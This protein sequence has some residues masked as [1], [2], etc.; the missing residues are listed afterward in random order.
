MCT[1]IWRDPLHWHR[2]EASSS[3][4]SDHWVSAWC[5]RQ[6]KSIELSKGNTCSCCLRLPVVHS[7]YAEFVD[8]VVFAIKNSQG[9]GYAWL[10]VFP[11]YMFWTI[12]RLGGNSGHFHVFQL[13][14]YS[15]TVWCHMSMSRIKWL[16]S[17]TVFSHYL[18]SL[19][20][21]EAQLSLRDRAS[22]LSV[23]IW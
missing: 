22:A 2:T 7:S 6:R 13:S 23:E 15:E 14:G 3:T 10:Q 11:D 4:E 18:L 19:N 5:W 1:D 21:Q 17:V 12:S 20:L 16:V 8:A 9:F